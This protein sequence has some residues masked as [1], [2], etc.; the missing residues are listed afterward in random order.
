VNLFDRF[1]KWLHDRVK[2]PEMPTPTPPMW[3][4]RIANDFIGLYP[5]ATVG[6][7]HRFAVLHAANAYQDGFRAGW[8]AK[9]YGDM[10]DAHDDYDPRALVNVLADE[11]LDRPV[12]VQGPEAFEH[13]TFVNERGVRR[14]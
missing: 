9:S 11:D 14:G 2:D 7:W 3:I 10:P 8:E 5:K 6:E 12:P 13:V 4:E 1:R